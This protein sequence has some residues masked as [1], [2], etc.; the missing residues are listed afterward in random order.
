MSGLIN[1]TTLSPV[2][3]VG[4][5]PYKF[6]VSFFQHHRMLQLEDR[7][8]WQTVK[9]GSASYI[10]AIQKACPSIIWKKAQVQQVLRE[11]DKVT[12]VTD[13]NEEVFDWVVFASH[14]DDTL[15]LIQDPSADERDVLGCFDYQDNFM[16]VHCDTSIMPKRQSQWASWHVHVTAQEKPQKNS[17]AHQVHYGFTYWM[18]SLQ[19]LPC[20][21]Q[22]FSTLNPN[23]PIAKK[24]IWVERHYRHPVFDQKA[25]A[26]QSRWQEINGNNRS[27]FCGAY[28]GWGFHEDGARSAARVVDQFA[29]LSN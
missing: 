27:S 12:V 8:Q 6:V 9:G 20:Q 13:R 25:I 15:K 10:R 14:A 29:S 1:G 18:N 23:F 28:W 3:Q 7:P 24:S 5:I 26:A 16:V 21:T 17:K 11:S 19:K 4:Q 22:V 2:E